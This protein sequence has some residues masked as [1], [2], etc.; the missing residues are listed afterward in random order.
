MDRQLVERFLSRIRQ[1]RALVIGDLMLDEYLWGKTERISPEAPV[2]VV[3]ISREDLRLGGAGN[4]INNLM[5]LGCQVHVAGV[6]G[7]DADGRLLRRLLEEKSVG[8]QGVLMSP[9][10]TTSRKTRIL[11][12]NQQMLRI[13]RESQ[14]PISPEME[15]RLADHVRR[16]A[17]DFQ[18]ILLSDYLKVVLTE[19]LLKEIVAIGREKGVPVVIDPKGSDFRKYRGA[20]LLTPNRKEAQTASHIAIV[21]EASLLQAGRSLAEALDLEALVLTRSEEGMTLFPRDGE[22]IHLPTEAREVY[23]VSGAGDTVL[24]MM[25]LGLAGELSL[26]EAARLA[27]VAAGIVVGKVGT[28]TVSPGEILEVIGRRHQD[29]DLKIKDRE[30]LAGILEMEREKGRTVVFTNGCFD[31]LHVGHVKYL[32]KARRLGDLLVLGLNSDESIRRLKGPRRP[33]INQDERAHILAAL[34]C[35]DYLVVFD[36]DTPLELIEALRPKILV[37]GGDY[38]PEGVVGKDLVESYGGRVELIQFVDGKSTT[39]II[40]KILQHYGEEGGLP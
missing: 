11:A 32:Q 40:E 18:V 28:S 14:N 17:E 16:V 34:D 21:D 9:D 8:I 29:T 7:D 33:L 1:I 3:D 12:S 27:N 6:L 13:D 4:V 5:T 22:E 30:V 19:G 39:N 23:D 36:E 2:Q 25:G 38:S 10:R 26:E 37:K 15:V 20:T 24:A 35:I 31:L